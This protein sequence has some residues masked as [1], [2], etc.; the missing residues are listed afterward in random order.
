[1]ANEHPVLQATLAMKWL[2]EDDPL[3]SRFATRWMAFNTL[4][5]YVTGATERDR[6]MQVILAYVETTTAAELLRVLD[7]QVTALASLPPGDSRLQPEDPKFR[8]RSTADMQIMMDQTAPAPQRLARLLAV[9]YQVRC[10]LLHGTK[11]PEVRRDR[12][13]VTWCLQILEVVLPEL[14]QDM[15]GGVILRDA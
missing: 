6:V 10:N 3:W 14:I 8:A 2:R 9:V 5:N 13:L 4:Y 12:D 15:S 1:M 11:D 7:C